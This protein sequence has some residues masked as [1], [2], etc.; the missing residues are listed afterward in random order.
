MER[1]AAEG[2]ESWNIESPNERKDTSRL[3]CQLTFRTI[4]IGKWCLRLPESSVL[5]AQE[6]I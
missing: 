3:T 2:S 5:D 4:W 1:A 6:Q